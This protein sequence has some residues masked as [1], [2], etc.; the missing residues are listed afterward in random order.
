MHNVKPLHVKKGVSKHSTSN[1]TEEFEGQSLARKMGYDL[2]PSED[3]PNRDGR[4]TPGVK[5]LGFGCKPASEIFL[6][7][8]TKQSRSKGTC[9]TNLKEVKIQIDEEGIKNPVFVTKDPVSGKLFLEHGHHRFYACKELNKDVPFWIIDFDDNSHPEG[10][11]SRLEFNQYHNKK[12][13]KKPHDMDDAL[14]YLNN[15]RDRGYFDEQL[16]IE[17]EKKRAKAVRKRANELLKRHY[18]AYSPQKRGGVITKFLEGV[19]TTKVNNHNAKEVKDRF[20]NNNWSPMIDNYEFAMN[21]L[22]FVIQMGKEGG[23]VGLVEDLLRR[24]LRKALKQQK[25]K[26]SLFSNSTPEQIKNHFKKVNLTVVAY[27]TSAKNEEGLSKLRQGLLN[28]MKNINQDDVFSPNTFVT[29]VLFNPQLLQPHEE[30]V[31]VV[32]EWNDTGEDFLEI[33]YSPLDK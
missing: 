15:G 19:V 23:Y 20:T 24:E 12:E 13:A 21:E 31:P 28:N 14:L 8:K 7:E 4:L 6:K 30:K 5:L 26:D 29:K 32:Y 9:A 11:N 27:T 3:N 25:D 16:K 17:D 22:T 33:P 18:S 2:Y 10:L 1:R